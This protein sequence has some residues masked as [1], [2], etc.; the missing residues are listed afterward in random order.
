[1]KT[2]LT[3]TSL[4]LSATVSTATAASVKLGTSTADS[5]NYGTFSSSLLQSVTLNGVTYTTDQLTQ[6]EMTS[7][8]G[9]SSSV[10]LQQNGAIATPT[11]QQRRDFLETDW[12]ADTGIINPSTDNNSSGANF[13][14]PVT[15][16]EGA[17]MFIY[18]ISSNPSSA[19][20]FKI[21]INGTQ[22][23][24][25][26]ANY[27]D[28]GVDTNSADVLSTSS[29]PSNLT[30]LLSLGTSVSSPNIEQSIVGVAIDFS[31]FGVALGDTVSSFTFNS[32]TASGS[33]TFDP[34]I[35]AAVP[36]PQSLALLAGLLALSSIAIRRRG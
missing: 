9:S 31:D 29:T 2:H 32:T 27:G 8:K 16:I 21:E 30:S 15:N 34:V 19:D 25:T 5:Q 36:E 14:S 26:S 4:I 35:I 28:S 12:F 18:E 6:I 23:T 13:V 20:S 17:D 33:S 1:M 10:L 22:L 3:I 7:F 11:A 24:F